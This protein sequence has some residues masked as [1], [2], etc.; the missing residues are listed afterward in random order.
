MIFHVDPHSPEPIF[1]QL[2]F[3]VKSAVA[4]GQLSEGDKLPSVRELAKELTVN[5]NTIV[6]ALE[7]LARDG[8]IVRRQGAGTFITGRGG[9]ELS[10]AVR[11]ERLDSL[12]RHAV[13]EAFH[14][15]FS[16]KEIRDAL[17]ASLDDVQFSR[18]KNP[19]GDS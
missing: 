9:S 6:R 1:E 2:I 5:P 8:V 17:R 7:A 19:K 18:P 12:M 15:G 10:D 4:R 16:A 3:Q 11:T 14:L 13:T